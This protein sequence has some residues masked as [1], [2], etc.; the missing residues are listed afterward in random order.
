MTTLAPLPRRGAAGL[1]MIV[2]MVILQLAIVGAVVTGA[3]DQDATV[4]RLD[5]ARSFYA[6]E[7]GVNLAVMELTTGLDQDGDGA[8]GTISNDGNS[9]ND[10]TFA[11]GQVVVTKA[12]VSGNTNLTCIGRSGSSRH[13]VTMTFVPSGNNGFPRRAVYCDWPNSIPQTRTWDGSSWS[14]QG[15]TTS[16]TAKQYWAVMK[17]CTKRPEMTAGYL[18]QG[19]DLEVATLSSSTWAAAQTFTANLGTNSERPF[20]IAYEQQSGRAL[21]AYRSGSSPTIYYRVWD[22][23]S[24]TAQQS[25]SSPLSGNPRFIKLIPKTNSNEIML[26]VL[27]DNNDL[28]AMVWDGSAFGNKV[29]LETNTSASG[30]ECMDAAY[31][32]GTGRCV[33]VW[34]QSGNNQ[35]Q[36]RIW[37]G[38]SWS[39]TSA[40]PSIGAVGLWVHV[41]SDSASSKLLLGCLDNAADINV[42]I[43]DG[44][45]WGTDLE[46]ETNT[47]T[48]T[49]RAFDVAFEGAGT[50][51]LVVWGLS[52]SSSPRYRVYDGSAW[53]AQQTAVALTNEPLIVQMAPDSTGTEI[54]TLFVVSGGQSSLHFLRFNGTTFDSYLQ[55]LNG[56]VSGPT[57]QEVFMIPDQPRGVAST[58]GLKG[59]TEAAPQ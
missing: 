3:R 1:A 2:V 18:C 44:T 10:P 59:W 39:A 4:Q 54:L 20:Y 17:R 53:G 51:G 26:L 29:T 24:W 43:W 19:N 23:A 40:V 9:A 11:T 55:M 50:T 5:A 35:P 13:E 32:A 46:V 37:N 34:C 45:A 8:I 12:V 36:Y 30:S 47:T 57:P 49:A 31:E 33:A 48:M 15:N 6:A 58:N 22:G 42:N 7:S 21:V 38:T 14:A 25:T 56:N 16:F 28:A 27:D 41:A 52:G